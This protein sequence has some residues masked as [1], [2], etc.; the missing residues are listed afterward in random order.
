MAVLIR[1]LE[2]QDQVESFDRGDEPLN[3]YQNNPQGSQGPNDPTLG[4]RQ[5]VSV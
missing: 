4:S 1:R 5:V 3:N 2:E